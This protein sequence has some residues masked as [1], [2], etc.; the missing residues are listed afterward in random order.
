[1]NRPKHNSI[2][3]VCLLGIIL[4]FTEVSVIDSAQAVNR[5]QA[6]RIHDRIAGV[7]PSESVLAAMV[8]DT[9]SQSD[10]NAAFT[11]ME[12]RNFYDVT[13]KNLVAPWTNES[14]TVFTPLNDY[15]ATV[16]GMIRDNVDIR[17]ILYDNVLY[18]G[19]ASL[20]L[21]ATLLPTTTIIRRLKIRA[22]T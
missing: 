1:M 8:A 18:V 7:P 4:V 21:P 16:I 3:A 11:A 5:E 6:K 19:K 10:I 9:S 12:N 17:K 20:G 14:Q 22:L 2:A 13:L 15:T